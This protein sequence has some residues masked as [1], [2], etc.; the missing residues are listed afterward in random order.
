MLDEKTVIKKFKKI[1]TRFGI[2]E[3][4]KTDP[5]TVF[6]RVQTICRD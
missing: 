3:I 1:F 4:V 2:P 5:E 6:S